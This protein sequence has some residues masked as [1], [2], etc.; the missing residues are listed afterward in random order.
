MGAWQ[1]LFRGTQ[2]LWI[3]RFR[4]I[5]ARPPRRG[6]SKPERWIALATQRRPGTPGSMKT[7]IDVRIENEHEIRPLILQRLERR[8]FLQNVAGL[9]AGALGA[10]L[11]RADELPRNS[12]PRAIF[13][14]AVEPD[15]KQRITVTVG[16]KKADLVGT[17]ERVI[18]A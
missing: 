10:P 5:H 12:N 4:S 13:G 16:P 2:E 11:L 1:G 9:L 6:R 18:Q 14:D 8:Q 17:T 3:G 15:W 7:S